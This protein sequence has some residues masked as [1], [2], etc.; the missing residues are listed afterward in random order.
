MLAQLTLSHTTRRYENGPSCRTV[1]RMRVPLQFGHLA[2]VFALVSYLRRF[3]P[4]TRSVWRG[5][6]SR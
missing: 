1:V 3:W 5:W 6:G 4:A 2:F